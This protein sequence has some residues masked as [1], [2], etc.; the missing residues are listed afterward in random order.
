MTGHRLNKQPAPASIETEDGPPTQ[1]AASTTVAAAT[2]NR[3]K[4]ESPGGFLLASSLQ[5]CFLLTLVGQFINRHC[6][7]YFWGALRPALLL[8]LRVSKW[9]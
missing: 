9:V 6:I 3:Q 8:C 5:Y 1:Q 2:I 7:I 4:G